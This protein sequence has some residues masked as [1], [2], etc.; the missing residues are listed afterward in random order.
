MRLAVIYRPRQ[1]PPVDQLPALV[2]GTADWLERY[3]GSAES[4]QLF[5]GGGGVAIIEMN[6]SAELHR[7]VAENPF[8]PY[9]DVEIRPVVDAD[10]AMKN[11]REVFGSAQAGDTD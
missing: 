6:K 8:T 3:R 10:E 9:A 7:M 2:Q 1:A 5:V 4:L 11:L